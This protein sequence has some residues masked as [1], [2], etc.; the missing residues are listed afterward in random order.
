[1]TPT[2]VHFARVTQVVGTTLFR[3]RVAALGLPEVAPLVA[4]LAACGVGRWL[5]AQDADLDHARW[6]L[7]GLRAR[8]GQ[9]L[10][11]DAQ[12]LPLSQW[13]SAVRRAPPD[14][15]LAAGDV[16]SLRLAFT[17]AAS[18]GIPALLIAPPASG[19]PCRALILLSPGEAEA[20]AVWLGE[21]LGAGRS[22]AS[23]DWITAAPLL[24]GL[25]RA[26]LLRGTPFARPDLEA[27][28][29][30]GVRAVAIGGAHPF[31]ITWAAA[32]SA[33]H[34][35]RK[36]M[37]FRD[38]EVRPDPPPFI[39]PEARRGTLLVAGL[40]SLGSVAAEHLAPHVAALV[41]A[42]PDR[43]DAYNPVRQAYRVADVGRPKAH[44]LRDHLME[45]WTS[46]EATQRLSAQS[47]IPV[48]ALDLAC[49]GERQVAELVER[50]GITAALVVTGAEADFAIA[51]ALR[52]LD[53][54]HVVG[55]CYPRAR[56]W[57][58]V[59]VDGRRGP[60]LDD[61]RGRVV[62]GPAA[63]LTPE[64]RA[65]YSQDGALEA[66][67]ATLV[68]SGWAAAWLARIA[69]Q[70]L[71]PAGLRER[72]LLEVLGAGRTCL[73]GGVGVEHTEHGPAYGVALPGQIHAWGRGSIA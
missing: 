64:Q 7:A 30:R 12:V 17:A 10:R 8:H 45:R 38:G 41:L 13:P 35:R 66:E 36:R 47:A 42:D 59:V 29:A 21:A 31:D 52:A 25:A 39:T 4:H 11:I 67:P 27:L 63:P 33:L 49:T 50:H 20:A 1:M 37:G 14:L 40:G 26:I 3:A 58:A 18:A 61:I 53:V 2:S 54:P 73:V 68:E 44:A 65:A 24:A 19:A 34:A 46:R 62:P 32:P 57:E 69:A 60:A 28:W 51:R 16:S 6:L 55:R 56:Y 23:W 71:A 72:W 5:L 15:V 70:L 9:A 43:V 48:V 22:A